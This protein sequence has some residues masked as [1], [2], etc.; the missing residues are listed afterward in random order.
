MD[1]HRSSFHGKGSSQEGAWESTEERKITTW[2]KER[3]EE[4][5]QKQ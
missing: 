2:Q 5:M 3:P 1:V 4:K